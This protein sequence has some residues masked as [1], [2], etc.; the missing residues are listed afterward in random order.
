MRVK[1]KKRHEI[2]CA[3]YGHLW[4]CQKRGQTRKPAHEW[5]LQAWATVVMASMISGRLTSL[6]HTS[7]FLG[8]ATPRMKRYSY[9]LVA[10]ASTCACRTWAQRQTQDFWLMCGLYFEALLVFALVETIVDWWVHFLAQLS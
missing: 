8:A 6:L 10:C 1:W 4:H 2:D 7:S 3:W 9:A 5:T